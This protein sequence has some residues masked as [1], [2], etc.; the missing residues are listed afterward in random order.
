MRTGLRNSAAALALAGVI[1]SSMPASAGPV[2]GNLASIGTAAPSSV[3]DVRRRGAGVAAGIVAGAI[4]GGLI[5]GAARP[6]YG[7]EPYYGPG[8]YDGPGYYDG[9]VYYYRPRYYRPAPVYIEPGPVYVDPPAVDAPNGP[10]RRC[11]VSTDST[12]GYGYW[13]P[14]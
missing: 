8:P 9:P 2:P 7:P 6:Y 5:A 4:V 1:A 11:W 13:Q 3:I 10:V 12:R 14:C